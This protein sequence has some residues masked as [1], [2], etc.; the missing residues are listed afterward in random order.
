MAASL[1]RLVVKRKKTRYE[2]RVF[3]KELS[4]SSGTNRDF[5]FLLGN[6]DVACGRPRVRFATGICPAETVPGRLAD[7]NA[8]RVDIVTRLAGS[9]QGVAN[10]YP[11]LD[12]NPVV[13]GRDDNL[14]RIVL[15]GLSGTIEVAGKTYNGQ[16]PKWSQLDDRSLAA[17]LTY[18]RGSWSNDSPPVSEELVSTV[19]AATSGRSS[20]WTADELESSAR[21]EIETKA[22]EEPTGDSTGVTEGERKIEQEQTE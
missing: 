7:I 21:I 8:V 10:R 3:A 18:I 13:N 6:H 1:R 16:M 5:R 15:H 17:V 14:A 9:G 20:P 4:V 22:P 2:D 19:R 11:P 12:G